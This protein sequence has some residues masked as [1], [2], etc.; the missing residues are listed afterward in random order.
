MCL[1]PRGTEEGSTLELDLENLQLVANR[2]VSFRLYSS[3]TRTEDTLGHVVE[4]TPG[5]WRPS[6]TCTRRSTP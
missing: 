2:P 4:F 5:G 1:V 3:L 6:S